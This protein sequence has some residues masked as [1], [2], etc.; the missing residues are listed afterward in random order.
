[1]QIL[2]YLQPA[3][4]PS[5]R[6]ADIFATGMLRFQTITMLCSTCSPVLRHM[7]KGAVAGFRSRLLSVQMLKICQLS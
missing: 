4:D 6:I 1:M 7:H 2:K 5:R 3:S